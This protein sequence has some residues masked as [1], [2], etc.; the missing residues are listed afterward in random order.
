M[1]NEPIQADALH[2]LCYNRGANG[3]CIMNPSKLM[4]C[5]NYVIIEGQIGDA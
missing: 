3:R 4:R 5:I 2:K 1:H